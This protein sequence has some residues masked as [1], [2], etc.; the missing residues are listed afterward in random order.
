MGKSPVT[1]V[2]KRV[3]SENVDEAATADDTSA[4]K[5]KNAHDTSSEALENQPSHVIPQTKA[6]LMAL[7]ATK[8]LPI[9]NKIQPAEL[10]K[11]NLQRIELFEQQYNRTKHL[12]TVPMSVRPTYLASALKPQFIEF[13]RYQE[14]RHLDQRSLIDFA[15]I[16][17]LWRQIHI[18]DDLIT[19]I[20]SHMP[21]QRPV[22]WQM[23]SAGK[24]H[25]KLPTVG[26]LKDK[27][28]I[29]DQASLTSY[30]LG[31]FG[32]MSY[33]FDRA[34][35][36]G[37]VLGY[38]F[39]CYYLSHL[40]IAYG[41]TPLSATSVKNYP[42]ATLDTAKLVRLL[43][44]LDVR[45]KKRI[46]QLAILCARVSVYKLDKHVEK[47][48]I[49]E[50]NEFNKKQQIAHLDKLIETGLMP[51]AEFDLDDDDEDN[52]DKK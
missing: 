46:Y 34:F 31:H 50:V 27:E 29:A 37:H 9:N 35:F 45:V 36:I 4:I 51:N 13:K 6:E 11:V 32:V 33:T 38:L 42:Y 17:M 24:N 14:V 40:S 39:C 7:F 12:Y 5:A 8:P 1:V 41:A 22:G 18:V 3:T 43:Q 10:D 47:M 44:T 15:G 49:K 20:V 23:T 48:L 19:D 26:R 16:D 25:L 21:A 28:Q 2:V 30:V 52:T